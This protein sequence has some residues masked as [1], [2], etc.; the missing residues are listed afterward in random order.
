MF[1]L[2][3]KKNDIAQPNGQ[4]Q[5]SQLEAIALSTGTA[6]NSFP[7]KI[8]REVHPIHGYYIGRVGRLL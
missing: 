5:S 7:L 6:S 8:A 4:Y 3:T 1:D 2:Y